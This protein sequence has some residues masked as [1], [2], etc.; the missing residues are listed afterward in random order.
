[1]DY[2]YERDSFHDR[3]EKMRRRRY[4]RMKRRERKIRR[5]KHFFYA[6]CFVG[7]VIVSCFAGNKVLS[8]NNPVPKQ[9]TQVERKADTKKDVKNKQYENREIQE[10]IETL[11]QTSGKYQKIYDHLEKYPEDL[12]KA[13][14]NNNEMLD[15]VLGYPGQTDTKNCRFT[16]KEQ[17]EAFPLLTQWD[18]R[19]G[20]ASYGSSCIG[21]SGCAPTCMSMVVLA[22]THNDKATPKAVADYASENGYYAEGSGTQWSFLSEGAGHFGIQAEELCL[23]KGKIVEELSEGNP[24]ICSM[25]PGDFTTQGHFIV[26]VGL[27]DGK[28]VVNDPNSRKRSN[29]LWDYDKLESQIKNLWVYTK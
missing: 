11:A 21:L 3:Q 22:L 18:K 12:L 10:A 29:M 23:S 16:N 25:R 15:F 5:I 26:L 17:T 2:N 9:D 4:V 13:L 27:Q 14:C 6:T 19:W 20:Y 24:I 7:C 28:I 8:R 1:M